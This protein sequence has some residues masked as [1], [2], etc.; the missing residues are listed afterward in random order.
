LF[1][2]LQPGPAAA[3]DTTQVMVAEGSPVRHVA[4]LAGTMVC[5][6]PGTAAERSLIAGMRARGIGFQLSGWQE[7]EEMMDAFASG[8]CPAVAGAGTALA[9]LRL[10]DAGAHGRLLPEA[11]AIT[12]VLTVTARRDPAWS[13]MVAWVVQAVLGDDGGGDD[14]LPIDAAALGLAPGWRARVRDAVGSHAEIVR[15]CLGDGSA[16]GLPPGPNQGWAAG[17]LIAPPAVE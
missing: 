12:P 11:L 16:L 6:E 1:G 15:R 9:A 17:G 4:D 3:Y 7:L 5:A 8:R 14:G 2:L 10:S 13:A